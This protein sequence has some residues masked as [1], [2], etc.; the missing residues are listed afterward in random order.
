VEYSLPIPVSAAILIVCSLITYQQL[1]RFAQGHVLAQE[2][3][4]LPQN[5]P[6]EITNQKLE[7]A[8]YPPEQHEQSHNRTLQ[9]KR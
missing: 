6:K 1:R 3:P 4:Q 5:R 2:E 8:S 9:F 7:K